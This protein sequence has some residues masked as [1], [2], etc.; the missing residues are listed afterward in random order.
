MGC[1]GS[2]A[3]DAKAI[4]RASASAEDLA[5]SG[6][7]VEAARLRHLVG[8]TKVETFPLGKTG[9][10]LRYAGFS[11]RGYEPGDPYQ[12]NQ[13]RYALLPAFAGK[14]DQMFMGIFDGHGVEGDAAANFVKDH[15]GGELSKLMS[16]DKY[17]FDFRRAFLQTFISLDEQ[18]HHASQFDDSR[19]GCTAIAACFRGNDLLVANIGNSRAIL[20]ER[21]GNRVIAYSLSVDQ[22]PYRRDERERV[23]ACGARVLTMAMAKGEEAINPDW[24]TDADDLEGAGDTPL[25]FGRSSQL[26]GYAF[27]RCLGDSMSANLGL[28]AEAEL[29]QKQLREQDQFI[30]LASDGVWEFLTNQNVCQTVMEYTEPVAA[31]QAIIGQA[32]AHWLQLEVR[33]DDITLIL[34]YIDSPE[35]QAPRPPSEDEVAEYENLVRN[36]GSR[37]SIVVRSSTA[38][39]IVSGE[40]LVNG[41]E[42]RPVRRGLSSAKKTQLGVT[43]QDDSHEIEEK[44]Q[45]GWK[46]QIVPKTDAEIGRIENALKGN[47]L[48]TNLASTQRKQ[49]YDVMK[50]K[51]VKAG[52]VVIKQ[53]DPGDEFYVLEL[54]ELTVSIERD[55]TSIEVLRY[56]PNPNGANPC[57]GELALMYSKPRAATVT[58]ATDGILWTIDRRSFRQILKTSSTKYLMRTLRSVE[59]LKSLAVGQLQRL[60]EL[61]TEVTYKAG[62]YVFRQGEQGDTFFIVSEG[63]AKVVKDLPE[64]GTKELGQIFSGQYFGERALLKHEPRAANVIAA[65]EGE[66]GSDLR[67]LYISK[68]N[69]EEVL[70]SLQVIIDKDAQWKF[71]FA[72]VK[73]LK[74]NAAGLSNVKLEN[75]IFQGVMGSSPPT[76][77]MLAEHAHKR[78][79]MRIHSKTEVIRMGL[80]QRLRLEMKLLTTLHGNQ[81]FMP[82]ALQTLEDDSYIY[83]V[84]PSRIACLLS[85]LIEEAEGPPAQPA[86]NEATARFYTAGIIAAIEHVHAQSPT[87]GGVICRNICTTAIGIAEN[88]YPQLMDMRFATTSEPPPRDY[89]GLAHYLAPEQVSG[90]G[91]G[92]GVDFWALGVVLYEMVT[93]QSPFLTGEARKDSEIPVYGRIVSHSSG[94]AVFSEDIILSKECRKL[95]NA[96]L[97]PDPDR[98]LGNKKPFYLKEL[99]E[100][101]WFGELQPP[102][103]QDYMRDFMWGDL[104]KG[105]MESPLAQMCKGMVEDAITAH[106]GIDQVDMRELYLEEVYEGDQEEFHG[107]TS[108]AVHST[109]QKK[110]GVAQ[111]IMEAARSKARARI[112]NEQRKARKMRRG[113]SIAEFE[114]EEE[115]EEEGGSRMTEVPRMTEALGNGRYTAPEPAPA[116]EEAQ[117]SGA[118]AGVD[119]NTQ[120]NR[121][122]NRRGSADAIIDGVVSDETLGAPPAAAPALEEVASTPVAENRASI[123][124]A[125]EETGKRASQLWRR[126]SNTV[127]DMGAQFALAVAATE[128]A[129]AAEEGKAANAKA[130]STPARVSFDDLLATVPR[131]DAKK[132]ALAAESAE[133]TPPKA[134]QG[135]IEA[136]L[137]EAQEVERAEA[138]ASKAAEAAASKA[139]EAV[140]SAAP[141]VSGLP[142]TPMQAPS[143]SPA[144]APATP[145]PAS[146]P[147]PARSAAHAA[148]ATPTVTPVSFDQLLANVPSTK[149]KT[150]HA[151]RTPVGPPI[152]FDQL[153][154]NVPSTKG[155]NDANGRRGSNRSPN[156]GSSVVV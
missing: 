84:Y 22:T 90:L 147:T 68:A 113:D 50:K 21:R 79:T 144:R 96:L 112:L 136:P 117:A 88:G 39:G 23:K 69:F 15:I 104:H 20:G 45:G 102:G 81:L 1:G 128:A 138:A 9:Y 100:H 131:S 57:F 52:E 156:L 58:A 66:D 122:G 24:L 130:V 47:F 114:E 78:Y 37:A 74:K 123:V 80:K 142:T 82:I 135:T 64:G 60:S 115:A 106:A 110:P 103:D 70:G 42:A 62:D 107:M 116:A 18:M 143:P 30:V 125:V 146:T 86:L 98:R 140:F 95:I 91:H 85:A 87:M 132:P 120:A 105:R 119:S 41:G 118:G 109:S 48:F 133:A 19:S 137:P 73:Q 63:T 71:Q 72:L 31:C 3:D 36:S 89:C 51:R 121:A 59:I 2:K 40:E 32:Y 111:A 94:K 10:V 75:F 155:K 150:G 99:R 134:G 12:G 124:E 56:R 101:Y 44:E 16:R 139:A 141:A 35:G 55:G 65:D 7:S 43:Q 145:G 148:P 13:D 67:C 29:V 93:K 153:L 83:S 129:E 49:I 27:T 127:E 108:T 54:G 8:S 46:M 38:S 151:A 61:L 149:G 92:K 77:Y 34:A 11:Q 154:A 6:V 17:K 53:G 152:S 26:P 25:V 97:E 28:N 126:I 33:T 76:I 5:K 4:Q 14:P